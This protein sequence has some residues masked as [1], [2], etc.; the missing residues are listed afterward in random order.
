MEYTSSK[1]KRPLEA[2]GLHFTIQS[3]LR[4][5]RRAA[6]AGARRARV[7]ELETGAMQPLDEVERDAG[8]VLKRDLVDEDP[9]I[10]E[11]CD[12]V[13]FLLAVEVELILEARASAAGHADA[14][15]VLG[16]E[17]FLLAHFADHL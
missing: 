3:G 4:A 15:S 6:S 5:E 12:P 13:A 17:A 9:H 11:V 16:A 10:I 2:S 7:V 1:R 14:Q 8:D